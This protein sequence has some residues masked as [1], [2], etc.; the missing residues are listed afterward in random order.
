MPTAA[1]LIGGLLLALTALVSSYLFIIS[2][3]PV[4]AG[5]GFYVVNGILGFYVGWRAIGNDPGFGGLGSI[6]SG[7]RGAFLLVAASAFVFGGWAVAVKLMSYFI[8]KFSGVL[9]TWFDSSMLYFTLITEPSI[10][11]ALVIGGCIS[12]I[13]AG[14]ANRHWT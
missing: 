5:F 11:S 12:G 14:L 7:L 1:N 3:A 4:Y 10:L 13:G 2:A 9:Q 6:V 8:K